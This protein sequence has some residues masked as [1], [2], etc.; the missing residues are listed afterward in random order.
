LL[1]FKV[2]ISQNSVLYNPTES[3]IYCF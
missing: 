2:K 1:Q 3:I